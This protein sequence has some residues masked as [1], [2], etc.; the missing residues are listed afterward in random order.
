MI[1]GQIMDPKHYIL[2][3]SNNKLIDEYFICAA[4]PSLP[5]I[6]HIYIC[7]SQYSSL[8]FFSLLPAATPLLALAA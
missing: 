2:F 1:M 3:T 4:C 8:F 5:C 7:E 6:N